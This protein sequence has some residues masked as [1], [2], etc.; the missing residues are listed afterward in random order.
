MT[1]TTPNRVHTA[2]RAAFI[3]TLLVFLALATALVASQLIGV[4]L[5]QPGWVTAASEALLVPSITAGVV[6]GL[7]GFISGY[8]MPKQSSGAE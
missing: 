4:L 6:F 8:L 1:T 2:C 5:F 3:V 7:V